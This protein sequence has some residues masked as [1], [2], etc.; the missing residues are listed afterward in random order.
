MNRSE[1]LELLKS[2]LKAKRVIHTLGVE[3]TAVWLAYIYGENIEF[4]STAA[5]LHDCAKFYEK[6]EQILLCEQFGIPLTEIERKNPALI[7][8]KLGKYM[9]KNRYLV[10]NEEILSAIRYHTTGHPAMTELEKIIYL[11]DYIEPGRK[12]DCKPHSLKKVRQAC[13]ANLDLRRFLVPFAR[14]TMY[15]GILST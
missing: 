10:K 13:F 9:A 1:I 14:S 4:A 3:Q 12:M 15:C 8:G 6:E 7:H 5:L 2:E 11:A